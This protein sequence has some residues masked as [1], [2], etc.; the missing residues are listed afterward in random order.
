MARTV[1][2]RCLI[3]GRLVLRH[4]GVAFR[5]GRVTDLQ[6]FLDGPQQQSPRVTAVPAN[7]RLLGVHV[8]IVD[9]NS[10]TVEILRAALEY[11]GG[12]VTTAPGAN[13]GKATLREVRPHVLVSDLAMPHDGLEMVREVI[14]FAAETGLVI[15]AIAVSAGTHGRGRDH[16]RESGFAV[17]IP[18]PLDPFVLANVVAKLAE[19]RGQT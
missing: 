14:V 4:E 6:C 15:P 7:Q 5:A 13:E 8:L 18:K 2:D 10:S 19:G 9:D 11:S 12:F 16:L 17:F 3:C 1:D